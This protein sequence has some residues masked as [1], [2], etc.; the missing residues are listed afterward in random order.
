MI[1]L[2]NLKIAIVTHV[3]ATG[4][5]FSLEEYLIPRVNTLILVG[6]P[7]AYTKDTRSFLRV[8]KKGK[9]ISEKKF[10]AWRGPGTIFYIK[11]VLLTFWWLMDVKSLD[12]FFGVDNLNAF[13]GNILKSFGKVKKTVFYT[14]DYV[15]NRFENKL[16]NNIYH[17]LDR[18]AVKKSDCVWNLSSIMTAEREKRGVSTEYRS[19]QIVVPVGTENVRHAISKKTREYNIAHMGHIIKK[20]GVQLLIEAIPYIVKKVPKFH[21]DIIGGGDYE[22]TIKK[23]V[24]RLKVSKYVTFHGFIKEHSDVEK[25]LDECEL[26]VAPYTDTPDNYVRYTDPGK[27]K[28]YLAA[29]LPVII[30][31]VPEIYRYIDKS[32]CGIS[33]NYK[34]QELADG[35]SSL[36]LDR[37]KLM[38]YRK[39]AI[40]VAKRFTW[41]KIFQKAFQQTISHK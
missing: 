24:K 19:K 25:L 35:I 12:Y 8:Y 37:Q 32:Q 11:D 9:L 7:F 15:P 31:K 41:D 6:H 13:V 27:V 4:P 22:N 40:L 23:I 20:Q 16:L 3:Y 1:N 28:A 36:L 33:V 29:G 34:S 18:L 17:F 21:L 26:G 14:I 10:I 39:N 30:T 2:K 5:S 38:L